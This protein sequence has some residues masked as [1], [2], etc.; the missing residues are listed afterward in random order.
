M[1]KGGSMESW[2]GDYF[3]QKWVADQKLAD[4]LLV[5]DGTSKVEKP[6]LRSICGQL[7]KL[8]PTPAPHTDTHKGLI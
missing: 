1:W 4:K 3:K 2:Q 5:L 7:S 6:Y 8:P